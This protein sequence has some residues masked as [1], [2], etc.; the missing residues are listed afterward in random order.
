MVI[1]LHRNHGARDAGLILKNDPGISGSLSKENWCTYLSDWI[2]G[3]ARCIPENHTLYV[4][5]EVII[6][7]TIS[8]LLEKWCLIWL[9]A[10][11]GVQEA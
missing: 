1:I 5:N 2:S 11:K 3:M 10:W 8:L 9:F 4:S 6:F 7:H